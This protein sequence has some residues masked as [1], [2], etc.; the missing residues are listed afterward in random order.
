[1]I[2]FGEIKEYQPYITQFDEFFQMQWPLE[3]AQ[4]DF[5]VIP[6]F[7]TPLIDPQA[8]YML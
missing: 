3:L 7:W 8:M 5:K 6:N 1:M 2:F 4:W